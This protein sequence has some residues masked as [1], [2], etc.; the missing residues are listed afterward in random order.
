MQ[1]LCTGVGKLTCVLLLKDVM[2]LI[3]SPEGYRI[4]I[5][6]QNR[7][8]K[9]NYKLAVE[10]GNFIKFDGNTLD[11]VH[12]K[13]I[14]DLDMM[15]AVKPEAGHQKMRFQIEAETS[16]PFALI[17]AF[18]NFQKATAPSESSNDFKLLH[19][20]SLRLGYMLDNQNANFCTD[21]APG[22]ENTK[23]CQYRINIRSTK[24]H[25]FNL[26]IQQVPKIEAI[27]TDIKYVSPQLI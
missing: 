8:L 12:M 15:V 11:R 22:L 20:D 27:T 9:T 18:V 3:K 17:D 26:N 25:A 10:V 13:G 4:S 19:L 16:Q 7:F 23:E 21:A 2:P 14:D 24:V 1:R 6:D 5:Q